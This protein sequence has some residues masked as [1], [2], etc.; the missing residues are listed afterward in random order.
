[1]GFFEAVLLPHAW[2][3]VLHRI[4]FVFTNWDT[5]SVR[6]SAVLIGCADLC[7]QPF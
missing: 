2:T 3:L 1:M 6:I 5:T 4:N 7:E